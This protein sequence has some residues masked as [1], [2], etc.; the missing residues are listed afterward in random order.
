MVVKNGYPGNRG[1]LP[2]WL[3][4]EG[5]YPQTALEY[6]REMGIFVHDALPGYQH[7]KT[8]GKFLTLFL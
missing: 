2:S 6:S 7:H 3:L 8:T 5:N 1:H 4:S